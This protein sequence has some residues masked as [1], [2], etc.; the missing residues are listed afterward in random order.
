MEPIITT[1]RLQL[2]LVTAAERGSPEFEWIHEL[3]SNEQSSWWSLY[4]ASK[5]HEDTENALKNILQ[6]VQKD[7]E[8]RTYRIAYAVHELLEDATESSERRTR[9]IGLITLRSLSDA[10]TT[11]LPR[12]GHGSTPTTLSLEIAYMFLP[13]SWGRG[14]A[15]ESILAMFDAC[16][17]VSETF[18]TPYE[19]VYVRAI[20]ND[21][22]EPSQRVME[23]CGMNEP[24]VLEFEG[25]R[26][27][28]AGKWRSQ[29]RLFVYGKHL[30]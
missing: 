23:K 5:T 29:H 25:G 21:E 26:F 9:F 4:G 13:V 20:V 22:N 7:G 19:K 8:E 10:E 6:V 18:W 1:P 3:R 30:V 27:F 24:E 12:L 11:S 14:F 15:T 28:I 16:A 2:T 17:R